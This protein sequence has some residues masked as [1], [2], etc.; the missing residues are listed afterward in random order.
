MRYALSLLMSLVVTA[1][2]VVPCFAAKTDALQEAIELYQKKDYTGAAQILQRRIDRDPEDATAHYYLANC[3]IGLG[4]L[5]GADSSYREALANNPS[6][7]IAWYATRTRKEIQRRLTQHKQP[8]AAAPQREED[9]FKTSV[10]E[11]KK[12][13][14]DRAQS[15]ASSRISCLEAQIIR[16]R[17]Q[18]DETLTYDIP[19]FF[20]S[21]RGRQHSNPFARSLKTDTA[22]KISQLERQISDIRK[23]ERIAI[24][25]SNSQI[26][27]TFSELAS[28]A[29]GTTGN[30]KPMLTSR[31]LYVRDYVHFT[32]DEPPPDLW[33]VPMKATAGKYLKP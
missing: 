6:S 7:Y 21:R 22:Y 14:R 24:E 23:Q 33:I 27:T 1:S 26:D 8:I 16:L 32:G 12:R 30:I 4:D 19:E 29:R 9:R 11:L 13:V 3:Q 10:E 25:R 15:Q 17:K 20:Y 2:F 5:N 28:Q 18:L 31:S